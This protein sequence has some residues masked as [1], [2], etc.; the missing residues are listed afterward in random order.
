MFKN[1]ESTYQIW[2]KPQRPHLEMYSFVG[3]KSV[4]AVVGLLRGTILSSQVNGLAVP[5]RNGSR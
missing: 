4:A 3:S 2:E 5:R 1:S